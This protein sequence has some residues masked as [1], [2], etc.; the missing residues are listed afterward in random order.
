QDAKM[1]DI[2][3]TAVENALSDLQLNN[4]FVDEDC[5]IID[6]RCS[7]PT[8]FNT[9]FID[10]NGNWEAIEN[11]PNQSLPPVNYAAVQLEQRNEEKFLKRLANL[12]TLGA[13]A[14]AAKQKKSAAS[15]VSSEV[16]DTVVENKK[17]TVVPPPATNY[18]DFCTQFN[19]LKRDPE[20][21]GKYF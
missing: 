18:S 9:G 19:Q 17:D 13:A 5:F 1:D 21:F 3:T 4:N 14:S 10:D 16:E 15:T 2:A 12:P 8:A 20:A 7:S 11:Q 6:F